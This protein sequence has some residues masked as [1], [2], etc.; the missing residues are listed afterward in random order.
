MES[1]SRLENSRCEVCNDFDRKYLTEWINMRQH[2]LAFDCT[3]EALLQSSSTCCYCRRIF[4]GIREFRDE[5]G[6]FVI[7]VSRLYIRGPADDPPHT[8]TLELYFR[9]SR[10][11]LELEFLAHSKDGTCKQVVLLSEYSRSYQGL[12]AAKSAIRHTEKVFQPI[13]PMC[14]ES[15]AW[16]HSHLDDC[17]KKHTKCAGNDEKLLPT[18]LL[19]ICRSSEGIFEVKLQDTKGLR[20]RYV[21]LSH[22]WGGSDTAQTTQ[23]TY[24]Q[25]FSGLAWSSTPKTFQDAIAFVHT[26]G[27]SYLWIDSYCIIQDSANDW[28]AES[29]Q[30]AEIYEN[31]YLT[32]AATV[33]VNNEAGCFWNENG[34][35]GRPLNDETIVSSD[36]QSLSVRKVMRHWKQIWTSNRATQYPLLTRAWVFQERL[37]A[38]RVLHFS[39]QELVWEC[40]QC[41][42]CQCGGF[43][44]RANAKT[45]SW[46]TNNSWR[47]AVELYT[48]LKLSRETDRLVAFRGFTEFYART[49][50]ANVERDCLAG[51][52]K[53]SLHLDLLWRVES[54]ANIDMNARVLC[55]CW[56]TEMQPSGDSAPH[57]FEQQALEQ[58]FHR[59]CQYSYSA[60][61]S[62]KCLERRWLCRYGK[63]S[64]AIGLDTNIEGLS[65]VDW[66][67]G[68]T[69]IPQL[70]LYERTHSIVHQHVLPD[71]PSWSWASASQSVKYWDE[72]RHSNQVKDWCRFHTEKPDETKDA[73]DVEQGEDTADVE[74]GEDAIDAA[75]DTTFA[76]KPV[77]LKAEGY[78]VPALLQYQDIRI[79]ESADNRQSFNKRASSVAWSHSILKYGIR[80]QS[81]SRDLD[82]HPDWIFS[83]D[84]PKFIPN[85]TQVFLFHVMGNVYLVLKE[86]WFFDTPCHRRLHL[87]RH[88]ESD[89]ATKIFQ[90]GLRASRITELEEQAA[91]AVI[92]RKQED[93][94]KQR[95]RER[96]VNWYGDLPIREPFSKIGEGSGRDT[97]SRSKEKGGSKEKRRTIENSVDDFEEQIKPPL[98]EPYVTFL[99][100]GILRI[101]QQRSNSVHN[102][103]HW[104]DKV[105]IE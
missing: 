94:E 14:D 19:H 36:L 105:K 25:M 35:Y 1:S 78:L 89:L 7:S 58:R 59:S 17:C 68:K 93:D 97:R 82:F 100:I 22:R 75:E 60:A 70:S 38:P 83:L 23:N 16:V 13:H 45:I 30:M 62:E 28:D 44:D 24:T 91:K 33:A 56:D 9:D 55:R 40:A 43:D 39:H 47:K 64:A 10:P 98:S 99:R 65:C 29:K 102:E 15:V 71:F 90:Q 72:L 77:S 57:M 67:Q 48:M 63:E 79:P 104:I 87:S 42:D 20:G 12:P 27:I 26:L 54:L 53:D 81:D 41:G 34:S 32:I 46:R 37:L 86:K 4:D 8:L 66:Y 84:G 69:S 73:E 31:S 51:L 76:E 6:D 61:C 21:C 74:Q 2:R 88:M 18:R 52:W 49:V 5:I 85:R 92:W 101:P 103:L 95:R 96:R 3:P 11:K 80:T 50:V